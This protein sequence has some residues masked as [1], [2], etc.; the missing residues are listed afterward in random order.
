MHYD[1]FSSP[2]TGLPSELFEPFFNAGREQLWRRGQMIYLQGQEPKYLYCLRDGSVRT[3]ILS[4]RGEEKLLTVYR[5]GSIFG[6]ASFFDG[7]PRVSTATAQTD[8]RIVRLSR[9]TVDALFLSHPELVSA[10]L[11]YLARTVRLLSGHVDTMSFQTADIRLRD[12]LLH[13]PASDSHIRV[14]QEELAAA[15]SVS[16]VTVSRILRTFSDAGYIRTAYGHI[17]LLDRAGLS[18]Y[19]P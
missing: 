1:S 16:R 18:D 3:S 2:N 10:M 5:A 19:L 14:T 9:P 15:I 17:I 8:C 6:E 4:D 13:Y 11:A 7:M 12:L